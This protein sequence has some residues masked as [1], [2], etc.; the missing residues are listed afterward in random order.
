MFCEERTALLETL[1]D[2]YHDMPAALGLA[3]NGGLLEVLT[4][5]GGSWTIIVTSPHGVS[6]VLAAGESWKTY[7]TEPEA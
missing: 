6:C 4:S 1:A 7:R 3:S 2:K 5:A